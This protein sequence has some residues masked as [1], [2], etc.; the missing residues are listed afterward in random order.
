VARSRSSGP[1]N[2][3]PKPE[4]NG[5]IDR[6]NAGA[7]QTLSQLGHAAP[8]FAI[9][10]PAIS[11]FTWS[12]IRFLAKPARILNNNLCK[13]DTKPAKEQNSYKRS[14][15]RHC[16]RTT[17]SWRRKS[18]IYSTDGRVNNG[19]RRSPGWTKGGA[20]VGSDRRH[21]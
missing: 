9:P 4:S 12:F 11:A 7:S 13:A 14:R 3:I 8:G 15:S 17:K 10:V 1:S 2:S 5:S 20:S 19:E 18:R 16:Y 21:T 6:G